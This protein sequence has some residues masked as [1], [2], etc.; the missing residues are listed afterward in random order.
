[1]PQI[2]D[3]WYGTTDRNKDLK[4]SQDELQKKKYI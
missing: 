4:L 1:M 2:I 3:N